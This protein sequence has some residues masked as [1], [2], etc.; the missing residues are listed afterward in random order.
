[1]HYD[2]ALKN[3]GMR[4]DP[5]KAL[6][7]PRPIAWVATVARDGTRNLA[8]YSFFNMVS[9][10]PP[11][12]MISSEVGKDSITNI[13]ETGEFTCSIVTRALHGQMNMSSA[14][15]DASVDEFVL[16][17]VEAAPST[18]VKPPRVAKS[19]AALECRLWKAVPLAPPDGHEDPHYTVLL[20]RVVAVYIDDAVIRDGRV[21]S[22]ALEPVARLG[23]MD[24]AVVNAASIFTANRPDVSA[25][26][27][28]AVIESKPWDGQYR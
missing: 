20:A 13:L 1:M 2:T 26:G 12:V 15:V 24:Y 16:A 9:D 7:V 27:R 6:I 10:Q 4:H 25:D 19:P 11:M 14:K 18:H 3:H 8:P 28:T 23:Y 17:G 21:D 22:A 5:L